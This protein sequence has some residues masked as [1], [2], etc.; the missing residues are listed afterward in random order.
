MLLSL[1]F[2]NK[3]KDIYTRLHLFFN[4]GDGSE[5]KGP[6]LCYT[7]YDYRLLRTLLGVMSEHPE[8]KAASVS[9]RNLLDLA[10]KIR[11]T[12]PET[13]KDW[14]D[15]LM[16]EED[17]EQSLDRM[18][19][20][21]DATRTPDGQFS[22]TFEGHNLMQ[23]LLKYPRPPSEWGAAAKKILPDWYQQWYGR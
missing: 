4:M 20:F 16:T 2:L 22:V 15:G 10:N 21:K 7:E 6:C 23:V 18:E 8:H 11:A 14:L 12:L 19:H 13:S 17:L 9:A 1:L 3:T 5:S